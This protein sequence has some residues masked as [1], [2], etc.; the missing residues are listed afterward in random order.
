MKVRLFSLF[1]A[2]V[3]AVVLTACAA[4]GSQQGS[5]TIRQGKIEQI[6]PTEIPTSHH[7]G[8]GP[9]SAASPAW[10]SAV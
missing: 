5:M 9:C 6:M 4:P 3:M 7:T 8:V 10:A 2:F 1:S